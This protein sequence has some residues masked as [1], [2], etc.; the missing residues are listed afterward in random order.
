MADYTAFLSKLFVAWPD[1]V[2]SFEFAD[3]LTDKNGFDTIRYPISY[4]MNQSMALDDTDV[5][6]VTWPTTGTTQTAM[7]KLIW[8]RVIGTALLTHTGTDPNGG[9]AT[10]AYLGAY[11]TAKM[12]GI[13][14]LNATG[15]SGSF[16]ITGQ[17]NG[18]TVE[19]FAGII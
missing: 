15:L 16:T 9:G 12:P 14:M 17:A 5:V 13:I 4:Y 7:T 19:L 1:D 10:T 8:A 2:D 11:G 18:T 3:V 6:T